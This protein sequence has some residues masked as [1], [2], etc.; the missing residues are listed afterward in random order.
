MTNKQSRSES[1][2]KGE[3]SIEKPITKA[4]AKEEMAR[5]KS[6]TSQLLKVTR[7][8]FQEER[9]RLPRRKS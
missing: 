7:K 3:A 6:I 5:F 9:E 1:H 4:E 8:E 2:G